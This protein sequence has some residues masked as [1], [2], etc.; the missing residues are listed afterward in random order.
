MSIDG[1]ITELLRRWNSGDQFAGDELVPLVEQEL[2]LIARRKLGRE[3]PGHL[4]QTTAL[5]NEL[6]LRVIDQRSLNWQNRAHFF[7]IAAQIM[8]RVLVDYA[9][10][11]TRKK[12][13]EGAMHVSLSEAAGTS[14]EV[15]AEVLSLSEALDRLSKID[16][17]KVQIVELRYFGGLSVEE[18]AEVLKLSGI[19]I[20]R[21]SNLARAWLQRELTREI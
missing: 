15:S 3:S 13:G 7:A 17:L 16:P 9:R 1:Q 20:I 10:A 14:R 8:R 2:R 6:Y 12:R 18:T 11:R 5:V 19:T 21:H 4:L